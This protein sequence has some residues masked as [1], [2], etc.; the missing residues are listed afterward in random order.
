MPAGR[1]RRGGGRAEPA[2]GGCRPR[3]GRRLRLRPGRRRLLYLVLASAWFDGSSRA[4]VVLQQRQDVPHAQY[5]RRPRRRRRGEERR[6]GGAVVGTARRPASAAR[7]SPHLTHGD[8]QR[9]AAR[10]VRAG[11]RRGDRAD[12]GGGDEQGRARPRGGR[13]RRR[14]A[15]PGGALRRHAR[16]VPVLLLLLLRNPR[17]GVPGRQPGAARPPRGGERFH[18]R[19]GRVRPGAAPTPP[20]TTTW[21]SSCCAAT[22]TAAS[23]GSS[24]SGSFAPCARTRS[25]SR[26][27]Q[28]RRSS[29]W[30]TSSTWRPR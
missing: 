22:R 6:V 19:P 17:G 16:A 24:P 8:P 27:R 23:S 14:G 3:L 12:R 26:R 5:G 9:P 21:A 15:R 11:R 29:R 20:S 30:P 4:V 1:E 25:G 7:P 13:L 2:T 10:R 28:S 18:R